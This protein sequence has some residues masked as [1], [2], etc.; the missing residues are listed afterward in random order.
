[1]RKE[2]LFKLAEKKE[3][4]HYQFIDT[5][6]IAWIKR[7]K[8][9]FKK[10]KKIKLP[11]RETLK[12]F[13][14]LKNWFLTF[15]GIDSIHGMRHS[16]RVAINTILIANSFLYRRKLENL[17]IAAVLHDIRRKNDKGDPFHGLRA[18]DW[19]KKNA[20]LVG[21][22]FK[23][24]FQDNDMEEIYWSIFF[25]GLHNTNFKNNKNYSKFRKS[26]DI[27]RT[28]DALD[29]Y[30]LPKIK[31]WFNEELLGLRIATI[32]KKTA[33]ELVIKSEQNF[34]KGKNSSESIL[35]ILK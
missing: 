4:P 34:L 33:L 9:K 6:T 14:P 32:F 2:S 8:P 13:I 25:H 24:E 3:L 26:I 18:A 31:W 20:I 21:K 19:F 17:I 11:D 7:N 27:I 22:K 16:L 35:N 15:R 28:A 12:R 10:T 30:R 29:R 5:G 1:M 23:I